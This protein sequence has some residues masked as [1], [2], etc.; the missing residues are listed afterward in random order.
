MKKRTELAPKGH[1]FQHAKKLREALLIIRQ[2][3]SSLKRSPISHRSVLFGAL[4]VVAL[5]FGTAATASAASINHLSENSSSTS[6]NASLLVVSDNGTESI[7]VPAATKRTVAEILES[8][9]YDPANFKDDKGNRIDRKQAILPGSR[10]IV[11]SNSV[12][13]SSTTIELNLPDVLTEDSS[14]YVGQTLIETPGQV[15]SALKTTVV[16]RDLSK[17]STL[18]LVAPQSFAGG[19]PEAELT[20][21]AEEVYITVIEAPRARVLTVGTKPCDSEYLCKFL[22]AGGSM[23]LTVTGDYIQPLGASHEWTTYYGS[24]GHETGAV[25]F[26]ATTGTPIYAVAAG[27]VVEAG[28]HGAGG[29]V[30]VVRHGDGTLTGYAHMVEHPVV[31]SGEKVKA[32]QLLGFVG[33]TGRS[34]GPHL[35]FEAWKSSAWVDAIPAYE[36]MRDRG[37]DIGLCSGGPCELSKKN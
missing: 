1:G 15:G 25:D 14:L 27:T 35:H 31:K 29:N 9:G 30:A 8:R 2:R 4:V 3:E 20:Q 32:G 13:G 12:E 16:H 7:S 21:S 33:S 11:Y 34:T 5:T 24:K 18:P 37:L 28:N 17:L 10:A 19:A 22:E 23:T 6:S 36:Y 26:P